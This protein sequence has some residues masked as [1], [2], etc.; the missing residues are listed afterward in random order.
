MTEINWQY[1]S[2]I[3]SALHKTS[4]KSIWP[5]E[6]RNASNPIDF[7]MKPILQALTTPHETQLTTWIHKF[8]VLCSSLPHQHSDL[9]R[10]CHL[11]T[12]P[13]LPF[14]PRILCTFYPLQAVTSWPWRFYDSR[15]ADI[16]AGP[17]NS[18]SSWEWWEGKTKTW[19]PTQAICLTKYPLNNPVQQDNKSLNVL[20]I[21]G[22]E[23]MCYIEQC[24]PDFNI[25][26]NK[27]EM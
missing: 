17:K 25:H 18:I 1:C 12:L 16:D 3:K 23:N 7:Q 15:N 19:C 26:M 8:L 24:F 5:C 22:D 11:K 14:H 20:S 13:F 9:N 2:Q 6:F 27:L 4:N 10:L 21:E